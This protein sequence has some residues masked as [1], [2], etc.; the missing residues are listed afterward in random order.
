MVSKRADSER[1]NRQCSSGTTQWR[2]TGESG[3]VSA[4]GTGALFARGVDGNGRTREGESKGEIE[5]RNETR[6]DSGSQK[7]THW[8]VC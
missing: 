8:N 1:T 5:R 3:E 4:I 7:R 2:A 6:I